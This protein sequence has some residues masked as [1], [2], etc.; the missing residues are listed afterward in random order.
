MHAIRTGRRGMERARPQTPLME[1]RDAPPPREPSCRP[2]VAQ[3]C[4]V[5][6]RP[7]HPQPPPQKKKGSGPRLQNQRTDVWGGRVPDPGH[8]S[9]PLGNRKE[10][11]RTRPPPPTQPTTRRAGDWSRKPGGARSTLNGA[12]STLQGDRPKRAPQKAG[13][14]GGDANTA[15]VREN[16]HTTDR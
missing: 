6:D 15:G 11:A 13:G 2:N 16:E 4:G 10:D 9:T 12:T 3:R 5:G 14:R 1:A 8:H 7:S